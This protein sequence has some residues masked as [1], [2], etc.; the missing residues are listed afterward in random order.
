[1]AQENII[2]MIGDAYDNEK[3]NFLLSKL[4]I[5]AFKGQSSNSGDMTIGEYITY[6]LIKEIKKDSNTV[7]EAWTNIVRKNFMDEKNSI[8]QNILIQSLLAFYNSTKINIDDIIK[9]FENNSDDGW[10]S[11]KLKEPDSNSTTAAQII[12]NNTD[13]TKDFD[14]KKYHKDFVDS[15]FKGTYFRPIT[16]LILNNQT[17]ALKKIV[18][19][20]KDKTKILNPFPQ[21]V[22]DIPDNSLLSSISNLTIDRLIYQLTNKDSA[23]SYLINSGIFYK[24]SLGILT[25]KE[26]LDSNK[27]S[28]IKPEEISFNYNVYSNNVANDKGLVQYINPMFYV[29]D[30]LRNKLTKEIVNEL[31]EYFPI[32]IAPVVGDNKKSEGFSPIATILNRLTAKDD[33]WS[34]DNTIDVLNVFMKQAIAIA[35]NIDGNDFKKFLMLNA[36]LGTVQQFSDNANINLYGTMNLIFNKI[37]TAHKAWCDANKKKFD[38]FEDNY[39]KLRDTILPKAEFVSFNNAYKYWC[40]T[41]D[42]EF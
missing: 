25:I 8:G 28:G 14:F 40:Q 7:V 24:S 39:N 5:D 16:M 36:L 13:Y 33:K 34:D 9:F 29:V 35:A 17:D 20:T 21:Q 4:G 2:Q 1:M 32:F 38:E 30:K 3:L 12:C 22:S 41:Y 18:K 15:N 11:S 19:N 27:I 10:I 31:N 26:S 6:L 42:K 23:L 37:N